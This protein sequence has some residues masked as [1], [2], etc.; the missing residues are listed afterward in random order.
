MGDLVDRPRVVL[1]VS[2]GIAAYKACELLRRLTESG[3][4]VRV[5][6]TAS[7]LHFVG[8][9]TW[10]ALSGHP[11]ST[12]VWDDV[13]EV[14]HVRIGQHADLVIVAPATAD[15]L[16]KAAHGLADDLLTNTLLTARCP[17]VFAPAMHTEM[18]EHPATQENVATLR[19]RGAVVIEPAV[20]RLTG[21]DTGKGRLPDPGEIFE[22]C[23]HV[24]RRHSLARG[25]T[26]PDLKG[27]HVVVSAGG[28]REPLD[29]VRFLGNRSSGKQGY[30]L[31]RTA[32]ARGAR[33]TLISA[34][35][36]LPD[37]AGVDIVPVGTAVQLR[38]AVLKAAE[39]ADVVV[40]AA[41]VADFR[42]ETY[43]AGKIKKK[44]GQEPEPIVLVRN[45]DILAEISADRARPGQ[46]VVGFAAETDDVLANGRTKLARKGC[47]LL[48]V[49]EVGERKTFGAEENEAVVLGADGTE[50]PVPHGPKEAL[51]EIVW[52]LVARRMK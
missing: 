39:D 21:V 6:P 35:T 50:T 1:G 13:H 47:D 33:V 18:W 42:P 19:R 17:V 41:A 2:G 14:P 3:H 48:V 32:A 23:R 28:T 40:M 16:A 29:P 24:L 10:S 12:E 30:A 51:A 52:D 44:D 49:N 4:D 8:A 31:A 20:G 5:V 37:P 7:A 45:P 26:E 15:M 38:E 9:A 11:V 34:N 27:R 22:V 36:G 25:V 43:A 46:V